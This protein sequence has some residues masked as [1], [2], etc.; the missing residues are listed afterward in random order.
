MSIVVVFEKNMQI[1][2]GHRGRDN[3]SLEF[4]ARSEALQN[5]AILY[6]SQL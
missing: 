5:D 6:P 3:A 4:D 1:T 2:R